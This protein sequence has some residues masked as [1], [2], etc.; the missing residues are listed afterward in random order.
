MC[1]YLCCPQRGSTSFLE[2]KTDLSGRLVV[3]PGFRL[4]L[5]LQN[6][7]VDPPR[8]NLKV[9]KQHVSSFFLVGI[10]S[11]RTVLKIAD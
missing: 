2:S 10:F 3:F 1:L 11:P 6:N 7:S 9:T 8:L 5:P 4:S